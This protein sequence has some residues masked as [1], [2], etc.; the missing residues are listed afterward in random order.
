MVPV[1]NTRRRSENSKKEE[2]SVKGGDVFKP[3]IETMAQRVLYGNWMTLGV[4]TL[5]QDY[6]LVWAVLAARIRRIT[7][8]IR[9]RVGLGTEAR[10]GRPFPYWTAV[11][12]NPGAPRPAG[13][14]RVVIPSGTYLA[15]N[16]GDSLAETYDFVYNHWE[17]SQ[18]EYVINRSGFCIEQY[19]PVGRNPEEVTLFM[20]L[21]S[22]AAWSEADS[23]P[24]VV[25]C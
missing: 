14:V 8:S 10:L 6:E 12:L 15:L 22:R 5:E 9:D 13:M 7:D 11:E 2:W 25:N 24:Q 17:N 1:M 18:S 20:P 3:T 16:R 23:E 4:E 19:G 21:A